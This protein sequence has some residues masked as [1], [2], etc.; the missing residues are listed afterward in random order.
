MKT[1]KQTKKLSFKSKKKV[2]KKNHIK[3][4]FRKKKIHTRGKSKKKTRHIKKTRK[5]RGA[6]DGKS[7]ISSRSSQ[8]AS[9]SQTATP[10]PVSIWNL[11]PLEI[12]QN[13][14]TPRSRERGMFG[15][16]DD[17][18]N[19]NDGN[20]ENLKKLLEKTKKKEEKI[21]DQFKK[22][23]S[24]EG[25][26]LQSITIT[27]EL[28]TITLKKDIISFL[29]KNF[30][31]IKDEKKNGEYWYCHFII[32]YGTVD[33]NQQ[34]SYNEKFGISE[35]EDP[36]PHLIN[37]ISGSKFDVK[38]LDSG[39][40]MSSI[41]RYYNIEQPQLK[42]W[43]EICNIYFPSLKLKGLILEETLKAAISASKLK[44]EQ[45]ITEDEYKK[46][47]EKALKGDPISQT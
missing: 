47:I 2:S 9:A 3:K 20:K 43:N 8:T 18:D 23:M 31:K 28:S 1:Q 30:D 13:L 35:G 27:Y 42:L 34:T 22:I 32:E 37:D 10:R 46:I 21:E 4:K 17:Y 36:C 11:R 33:E 45:Q 41:R 7:A 15:A 26:E 12:Q 38:E 24:S 6:G 19:D 40:L 44:N 29:L 14:I 39:E 25:N 5:K 16:L